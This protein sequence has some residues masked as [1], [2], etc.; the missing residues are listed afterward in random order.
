[1]DLVTCAAPSGTLQ[2]APLTGLRQST[3]S[4]KWE[5]FWDDDAYVA[6]CT[7]SDG[8]V[9]WYRLEEDAR[10]VLL[11]DPAP[12]A[13]RTSRRDPAL[14]TRAIMVRNTKDGTPRALLWVKRR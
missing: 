13:T 7:A 6:R 10:S 9:E 4:E 12:A 5:G 1:M 3:A 2:P 11:S 8:R 14:R